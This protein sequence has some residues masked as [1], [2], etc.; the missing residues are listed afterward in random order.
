MNNKDILITYAKGMII[1]SGIKESN[2]RG[3]LH[4]PVYLFSNE[5]IFIAIF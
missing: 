3:I 5:F 2:L 4:G 1:R